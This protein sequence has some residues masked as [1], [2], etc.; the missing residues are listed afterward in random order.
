[1]NWSK[2][3]YETQ[4]DD[5]NVALVDGFSNGTFGVS[6]YEDVLTHLA[7]GYKVARFRN[8]ESAQRVGDYLAEHYADELPRLDGEYRRS[9]PHDEFKQLPSAINLNEIV[10]TDDYFQSQINQFAVLPEK[11]NG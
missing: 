10:K 7:T 2:A 6:L 8:T 11:D 3:T 4:L 5:G 1:M 9:M